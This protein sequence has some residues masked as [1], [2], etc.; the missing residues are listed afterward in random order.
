MSSQSPAKTPSS[1]PPE[2]AV[3]PRFDPA[4]RRKKLWSYFWSY[5]GLFATGAFFL[6]LTNILSFAIPG[7]LGQAIDLM[8]QASVDDGMDFASVRSEVVAAAIAIILFAI[9]AGCARVFSRTFIFNAGRYIEFDIRNELYDHL[10]KFTPS[11]FGAN[12]TGDVTSRVTNDVTY[13]RLL[14]AITFLHVINTAIAYSI[15][16]ER[17]GALDWTLTLWC[18]APYPFLLFALRGVLRA[19]FNQ[20]KIVQAQLS[21]LSTRVQENLAGVGVIKSYGLEN[22]EKEKYS[23]NNEDFLAKNLKLAR[24][25]A[26]FMALMVLIASTGTFVVLLMGSRQVISGAMSLGA[27]VEFNAYIVALAFPTVA[28]GW[29]FSVWHRGLAGFERVCEILLV[30]AAFSDDPDAPATLPA[31]GEREAVGEIRFEHVSFGYDEEQTILHDI[32]LTIEA[33]TTVALVGKTGSGKS[34][35][36]KLIAR[37]YDPISGT[38]TIDGAPLRELPLRLYRN[39]VGFVPQDPFLFSMTIKQNIRFGLDALEYDETMIRSLPN[40]SLLE[41]KETTESVDERIA[42]AVEV[43]ALSSDIAGFKDG[44]D[45]LVGE[46]GVTLS[47][48]QKQR[49]TIAR[50]LLVDPRILILDDALASVDTQTESVI[51]DHLDHIMKGRTSLILTHRFNALT[52]VDRILVLDEGR[53]VEDGTHAE[54]LERGGVYADMFERQ[55]LQEQLAS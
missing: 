12:S 6:L 16:I 18:L 29:V 33:G 25:R 30:E 44:L 38:I 37:L 54:L 32:D 49:I 52:R 11:Y 55:R 43:A 28:M 31:P 26:L 47:G 14:F 2:E 4:L 13:V 23:E 36:A 34:T 5:K 24:I 41:G 39:E 19:L 35:F 42:E 22:Y 7:Y 10:A 9:G 46:R 53:V 45:T 3:G 1:D 21:T 8:R 51:L 50:A 15:A 17:M 20:T 27:F 48:G 40:R